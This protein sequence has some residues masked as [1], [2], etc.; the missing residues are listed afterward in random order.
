M[1]TFN[2][3]DVFVALGR[4]H[5]N[6]PALVSGSRQVTYVQLVEDAAQAAHALAAQGVERDQNV[7]LALR[8]GLDTVIYLI[9]L[10]MIDATA[11]IIDFRSPPADRAALADE[12]DLVLILGETAP[13]GAPYPAIAIGGEWK[14]RV[15]RQSKLPPESNR[16]GN[17]IAAISLTSGTTGRPL[18]LLIRHEDTLRRLTQNATRFTGGFGTYLNLSPLH[19]SAAR[20]QIICR[21]LMGWTVHI[22]PPIF[23][24]EEMVNDLIR[25]APDAT[26]MVPT[27]LRNVLQYAEGRPAPLFPSLKEFAC[28]GAVTQPHEKITALRTLS[29]VYADGYGSSLCGSISMLQSADIEAHSETIGKFMPHV[30]GEIVDDDDQ[31]LPFGTPGNIRIRTPTMVAGTYKDRTRP[32]GDRLKDGWVYPGDLGVIS[33]DGFLTIV[34]RSADTIIRGGGNVHPSEIESVIL[35]HPAIRE[36]YA[37]GYAHDREG[38][39]IGAVIVAKGD[40]TENDLV[41]YSRAHLPPDKRPRRFLIVDAAPLT[42]VGKVDKKAMR[43]LFESQ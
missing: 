27:I 7:G 25:L 1:S 13:L 32:F 40:V 38:E 31:P 2:L 34:G 5:L 29:P 15:A 11:V 21:L 22:Y 24:T 16:E 4:H 19:F 41:A 30:R 10:W 28:G 20:S 3:A 43:K 9:A 14:E 33:A 17:G 23:S 35:N 8:D 26:T 12:F 18:G 39:E 37:V 42:A 36:A 6:R